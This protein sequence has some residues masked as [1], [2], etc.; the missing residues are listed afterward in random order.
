MTE[1]ARR[2]PA[3]GHR[4]KES[5]LDNGQGQTGKKEQKG[6][7]EKTRSNQ[8]DQPSSN[9]EASSSQPVSVAH[10]T[11]LS[12]QL[13]PKPRLL[14][15]FSGTGSTAE[16]FRERGY[17]VVT[18]DINAKFRPDILVD[19]LE[20]DYEKAFAPG[21]FHVVAVS[22]PCTEYSAAMTCRPR[23]LAKA[24]AIV[25]RALDIIRYL[26]PRFWFVENPRTGMLK[27]RGILDGVT[28]VD[29][30][31]CQFC[32]WG[33]QKPTR[34]WGPPHLEKLRPKVCDWRAC[35]NLTRRANGYLGHKRTL[36]AT[37]RDGAPRIP[38]DLVGSNGG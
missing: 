10:D 14:D 7:K 9:F 29:V 37:P 3:A 28:Y 13:F 31:Y 2:N 22:P 27:D 8:N 26:E 24:D 34:I 35:P 30:D 20:W 25:E 12:P 18:L 38:L 16:A 23:E 21:Y 33:Y 19:I 5:G 6:T 36:G 17:E 1:D 15:L 4:S 11:S 32:D